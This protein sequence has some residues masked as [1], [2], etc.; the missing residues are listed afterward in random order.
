MHGYSDNVAGATEPIDFTK[1]ASAAVPA[2][3]H[4][5]TKIP[6]RKVSN[7]VGRNRGS[8]MDDWFDQFFNYPANTTRTKGIRQWCHHQ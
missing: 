7:N 3:V 2:V 6:A 1:A 8:S 5:K 4:I